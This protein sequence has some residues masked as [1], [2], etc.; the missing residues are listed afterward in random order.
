MLRVAVVYAVV[1]LGVAEAADIFL[2]RLQLPEWTV[3]L[4]VA[5]VLLGFPIAVGLSWAFDVGPAGVRRTDVDRDPET[6]RAVSAMV[7]VGGALVLSLAAGAWLFFQPVDPELVEKRVAVAPFE[8]HTGDPALDPVGRMVADVTTQALTRTHLVEVIPV[9][10]T[11]LVAEK[12]RAAPASAMD[13]DP[14]RAL[15]RE[16]GAR[17][18]VTGAVY[19]EGEGL[20]LQAHLLDGRRSRVLSAL[21]PVTGAVADPGA[22]ISELA[23]RVTGAVAQRLDPRSQGFISYLPDPPSYRAYRRFSE[24]MDLFMESRYREAA[25]EFEAATRLDS[26]Y[27]D[28]ILWLSVA[29]MNMGDLPIVDSLLSLADRRAG[30]DLAPVQATLMEMERAWLEGD[31]RAAYRAATRWAELAPAGPPRYQAA[32]EALQVGRYREAA[33]I[34]AALDPRRADLQGWWGYFLVRTDALHLLG[35]HRD[36]LAVAREGQ[37]LYPT[38]RRHLG[39]EI[40]ALAAMGRLDEMH[41]VLAEVETLPED[42]GPDLGSFLEETG[43]WLRRHGHREESR[44][45]FERAIRWYE[46]HVTE[47]ASSVGVRHDYGDVLYYLG[48]LDTAA[49]VFRQLA[50]D[51]PEN[52]SYPGHLGVLAAV[53]GDAEE[54]RRYD[55]ILADWEGP[56]LRGSNTLW[57][58][59]IAANLGEPDRALRLL[60]QALNEGVPRSA[61][62]HRTV[63][64]EPIRDH[65]SFREIMRPRG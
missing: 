36:E 39:L 58:A 16:T 33:T 38:D 42:P 30:G 62:L 41:A 12:F 4:V 54:A 24:G 20:R 57:R 53:R 27:V 64:L 17:Y 21:D 13:G 40:R 37:R 28:A 15:A 8:N 23:S 55:T 46:A 35:E 25:E 63:V 5:L 45:V 34:L 60:L 10:T 29:H 49:A 7:A 14:V 9:S 6:S 18:V 11:V 22:V 56:Y 19:R 26:T 65:P 52:V 3:T 32:Y 47:E 50:T 48:R 61:G 2:P 31:N 44:R 59:A 51:R 1:G 43:L